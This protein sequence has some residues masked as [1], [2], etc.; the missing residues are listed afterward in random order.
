MC[1]ACA[2][3]KAAPAGARRRK[4]WDL[5]TRLHCSV[6]GTCL[7]LG[8][9]RRIER[10]LQ[11]QSPK[12]V[13]EFAIHGNFV[14]WAGQGGSV[15][16]QMNKLLDRRY[17]SAIRRFAAATGGEAIAAL[18][19]ASLA[20]GDIPGPYWA[21]LTHPDAPEKLVMRT[22]GHV[23]MLS[24][25]VGAANRADIR[26]L[27]ALEEE[28]DALAEAIAGLKQRLAERD[29]DTMRMLDQH[30][31][32]VRDLSGRLSRARAIEQRLEETEDRLRLLESGDAFQM[33]AADLDRSTHRLAD[34]ESELEESRS[35][36]AALR[37]DNAGLAQ[38]HQRIEEMIGAVAA[39]CEAME[40][41][42]REHLAPTL[43]AEAEQADPRRPS[44]ICAGAGSSTSA[45]AAAP[46]PTCGRWSNAAAA[47]SS[48]MTAAWRSRPAASTAFSAAA[49]R[50]SARSIASVTMPVCGRNGSVGSGPR[51]SCHCAPAVC[52]P[53]SRV[54]AGSA[55]KP[56]I[57]RPAGGRTTSGEYARC[58]SEQKQR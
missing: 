48:T 10:R 3:A 35:T 27:M 2:M 26:R 55:K 5:D 58:E 7:T 17:A 53:L 38:A 28:R 30:A 44:S 16:R 15:A 1:D 12:E 51:R 49:T 4:L 22:F 52:R 41:M 34:A 47:S 20:D 45:V 21:L 8:D 9:L 50:S 23:H 13:S 33:V 24:H 39:E 37:R 40:R 31:V 57:N 6:V 54:C 14:V 29:R 46:S 19:E 32:E 11:I 25:M 36:I 18:W 43:E 56:S 42:V